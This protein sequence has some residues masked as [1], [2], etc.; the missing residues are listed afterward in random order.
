M[1]YPPF[2]VTLESVS[3]LENTVH[4]I[5]T[6]CWVKGLDVTNPCTLGAKTASVLHLAVDLLR[7]AL[8][9]KT[10]LF[11]N[12]DVYEIVDCCLIV[13]TRLFPSEADFRRVAG[14]FL[15]GWKRQTF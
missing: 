3:L 1:S 12:G 6:L 8:L 4:V 10:H 15:C 7:V 13:A 2:P 5:F 9:W 14:G 11:R